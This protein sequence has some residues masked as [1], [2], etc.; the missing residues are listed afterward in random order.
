MFNFTITKE[1]LIPEKTTYLMLAQLGDTDS[2]I[3]AAELKKHPY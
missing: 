2:H 3:P 1:M